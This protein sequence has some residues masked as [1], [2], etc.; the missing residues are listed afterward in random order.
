MKSG[1]DRRQERKKERKKESGKT[2]S[3]G[4]LVE[5]IGVEC[6]GHIN[7]NIY[8]RSVEVN[9][10]VSLSFHILNYTVESIPLILRILNTCI[11][12]S[13]R[14]LVY[15]QPNPYSQSISRY[16]NEAL[17]RFAA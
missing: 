8:I 7:W 14:M 13:R 12:E 17:K 4:R 9:C 1:K 11:F 5:T 10:M 6:E 2:E 15:S 3:G 16:Q